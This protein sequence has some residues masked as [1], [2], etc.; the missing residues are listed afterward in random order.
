MYVFAFPVSVTLFVPSPIVNDGL[1]AVVLDNVPTDPLSL[2][3]L[4]RVYPVE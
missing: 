2:A 3:Q 1:A 4:F